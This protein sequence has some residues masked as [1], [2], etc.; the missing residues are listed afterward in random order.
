MTATAHLPATTWAAAHRAV[1]SLLTVIVLAVAV[2]L[3]VVL[4]TRDSTAGS[5][6]PDLPAYEDTCA[7]AMVG[8]PC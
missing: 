1:L 6:L 3:A 5:V 7:G 4:L 8:S 2:T